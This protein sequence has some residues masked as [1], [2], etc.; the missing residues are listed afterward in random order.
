MR[1]F[2]AIELGLSAVTGAAIGA[3]LG[4][5]LLQN[6]TAAPK[7]AGQ[8][9]GFPNMFG[10]LVSPWTPGCI[11]AYDPFGNIIGCQNDPYGNLAYGFGFG[12][13]GLGGRYGGFHSGGH[14]GGGHGGGGGHK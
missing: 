12:A 7:P 4:W 8:I 13:P 2:S 1:K 9:F 10:E 3:G 6:Q 11:P 5:L 14:P